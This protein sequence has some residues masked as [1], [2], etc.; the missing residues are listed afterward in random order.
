MHHRAPI[1]CSL[2]LA[3]LAAPAS[4][5]ISR[6]VADE[7]FYH[8][9]PIAWRDSNNDTYR[10]G[11]FNGMTA[12]LD[13]LQG[14]GV[15]AVWMNP[16]FPSPAYHGYHHRAPSTV[17]SWFGVESDFFNFVAAA[18][19][20]GIKVFVDLVVYGVNRDDIYFQSANGNPSSPYDTWLAFTNSGNT[21]YTGSTYTT[22]TGSSVRF[23]N[24]DLR[25]ATN[26]GA[27]RNQM[28][29]WSRHWLDPNNDG[30]PS[31]GIDGFRL[32][33][34]WVQYGTGPDGWG[35]N[36][37]DFWMPW[38]AALRQ[39]NAQVFTFAEQ[40]DWGSYGAE[41]L[42]A[43]NAAM[44]K[45][46]LFAI[47]DAVNNESAAGVSSAILSTLA[48]LPVD[49][50]A[51]G[52]TFMAELGDHD[53]DRFMSVTGNNWGRARAAA[54]V[55]MTQPFTPMMYF[56]DEIGML[57]TQGNWGTDANDIPRREPFKWSAV[58]GAPMTNYFQQ[59]SSAYNARFSQNNDGRSVQEQQGVAGSL[60]ETY[61]SLIAVRKNSVALKAGTY[62]AFSAGHSA[63]YACLRHADAAHGGPQGALVL[64]NMS[65]ASVTTTVNLS[66]VTVGGGSTTPT[67]LFGPALPAITDANKAAYPVT[68][69]AYT[70]VIA[71]ADLSPPPAPVAPADIDGR[72]IPA[73][74]GPSGTVGTAHALQTC[75]TGFGDNLNELDG[76]YLKASPATI[77]GALRVGITGNLEGNANAVVL[78]VDTGSGGQNVLAT[79]NISSPPAGIAE[80]TGTR[81]DAGFSPDTM[82]FMNASGGS[83]LYV[84]QVSLPASPGVAAKTYR[85]SVGRGTGRCL[86]N[87]GANPNNLF[88]A[89][90]N[91]NASG[92]TGSGVSGAAAATTGLEM[93]I[94]YRDL[95]GAG[96]PSCGTLLVGAF[97]TS[98]S[99]SA[100]NQFLPGLPLGTGNPGT[101]PNLTGYAGLQFLAVQIPAA[102]DLDD[103]T[104]T[105]AP[106]GGVD[107][108]DLLYFLGQYEA[109]APAADLDDGTTSGVPDGGV[110]INDLLF[111]LGRYE[112]GC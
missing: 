17:N 34:V 43:F 77:A 14:L 49:A 65:G 6:P 30:N 103:G 84:D 27:M 106:D 45:P 23:I 25:D 93:L 8:F 81:L 85:G 82:F 18:H 24:W 111:F 74:A 94:P 90:D 71:T 76:L 72:A 66:G 63:I 21:Q 41:F 11:D 9:M 19:A 99:G 32:D 110:D 47:R 15:T 22:W 51:T 80:L 108:N 40:A 73:E 53:V 13:Y 87:G 104:G 10:Y 62:A 107:I 102:A 101:A 100:S 16:I 92:V 33:H 7:V 2:I 39:T 59:N 97:L 91:T 60:L 89:F 57:G 61:R 12:S 1:A 109:G 48:V 42:P 98:S 38:H 29:A 96:G 52:R 55:L 46:M 44:A 56:G 4:A 88:V 35:Y 95:F 37:D 50:A 28:I 3:G 79:S 5:Q 67:P 105:G 31:D 26:A 20:R 70:S 75:A 64:I 36:L 112:G 86:L 54:A 83:V 78:L 69:P 68:L 58:A